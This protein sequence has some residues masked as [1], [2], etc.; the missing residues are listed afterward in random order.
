MMF[1]VL[2]TDT[3]D[4][5]TQLNEKFIKARRDYESLLEASMAQ[6]PTVYDYPHSTPQQNH[7]NAYPPNQHN[8]QSQQQIPQ[9][10]YQ[11]QR[12]T[13]AL[14]GQYNQLPGP[15]SQ[16]YPS[17][18]SHVSPGDQYPQ[19][20]G[21]SST[22]SATIPQPAFHFLPANAAQRPPDS[23]QQ[24]LPTVMPFTSHYYQDPLSI[25]TPTPNPPQELGTGNYEAHIDQ[26]YT[27]PR[28]DTL[29]QLQP[30]PQSQQQLPLH[31]LPQAS[32]VVPQQPS[33]PAPLQPNI[34]HSAPPSALTPGQQQQQQQNQQN[35]PTYQPAQYKAYSP[36]LGQSQPQTFQQNNMPYS[37]DHVGLPNLSRSEVSDVQDD[38]SDFYR[39]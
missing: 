11:Q 3:L 15:Q 7:T 25:P 34:Q 23:T 8:Y 6:P 36:G 26:H 38:A 31:S 22:S 21:P 20:N 10:S 33:Y 19:F 16:Y 9:Q 28:P 29:N 32:Q 17:Q 24:P 12:P 37:S 39:T 4:D 30:Q 18:T 5:F 1:D 14:Q 13:S 2:L 27:S 35:P